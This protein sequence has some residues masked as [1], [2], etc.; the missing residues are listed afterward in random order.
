MLVSELVLRLQ[1]LIE[2]NPDIKDEAVYIHSPYNRATK[3]ETQQVT[4]D[5]L[6]GYVEID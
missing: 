6:W 2:E 3:Q 1:E 5:P 4:V